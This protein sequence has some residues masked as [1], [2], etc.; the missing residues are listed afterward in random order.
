MIII[1]VISII[2]FSLFPIIYFLIGNFEGFMFTINHLFESISGE[3]ISILS[4]LIILIL[5]ATPLLIGLS[6]LSLSK[7]N[8][9]DIL[10]WIWIIVGL[11]FN[12]FYIPRGD[13]SRYFMIILPALIIL[14][15]KYLSTIKLNKKYIYL[16]LFS[17]IIS[18][19][20]FIIL[21]LNSRIMFPHIINNYFNTVKH[22]NFNFMFPYSI[23]QGS[24][25]A[26]SFLAILI[27]LIF[28][29]LFFILTFFK[30]YR[31]IFLILFISLGLSFNIFLSGEYLL[32]LS[33]PD[34]N[35]IIY[36]MVDYTKQNNLPYP[37]YSTNKG[38]LDYLYDH[39]LYPDRRKIVSYRI[40]DETIN[41]I[42]DKLKKK[43]GTIVFLDFI[44]K[45]KKERLDSIENCKLIKTFSDKKINIGYI[46][47]CHKY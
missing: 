10:F 37:I 40:D 30:K 16:G 47:Y 18:Y 4:K 13:F 35:K 15:S 32:H 34:V 17:F 25:F 33:Q 11:A 21:N 1:S 44:A 38:I 46:Y 31:K 43:G 7:F 8:K 20:I 6:L 41:G 3:R 39:N 36:E 2:I 29:L 26:I 27:M 42:S 23:S 19:I 45:I 22:L 5:W 28:S 12:L 14:S 9:K 24:W